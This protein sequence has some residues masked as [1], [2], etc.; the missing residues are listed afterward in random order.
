M[1]LESL[2]QSKHFLE[3]KA[4]RGLTDT[5]I[6]DI[7]KTGRAKFSHTSPLVTFRKHFNGLTYCIVFNPSTNV[8]VTCFAKYLYK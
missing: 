1:I 2:K 5:E 7:L 6:E 3:R 4:Q 8:L